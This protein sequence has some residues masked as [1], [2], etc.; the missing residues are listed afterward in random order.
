MHQ[1]RVQQNKDSL[2]DI[3]KSLSNSYT[4]FSAIP[5]S[6]IYPQSAAVGMITIDYDLAVPGLST[7]TEIA[8][9]LFAKSGAVK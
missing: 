6:S 9:S 7:F 5:R 1:P 8:S 2:L 4:I 3:Y